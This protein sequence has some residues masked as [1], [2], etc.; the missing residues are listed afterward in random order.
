MKKRNAVALAVFLAFVM[1][2]VALGLLIAFALGQAN[3]NPRMLAGK[4]ILQVDLETAVLEYVPPDPIAQLTMKEAPQMRPLVEALTRAATDDDV[5][6]LIARVGQGGLGIAQ[7]QEIRDAVIAFRAAGKPAYAYAETF[8]EVSSGNASYYL[9]TAFDKIYLQPA[10]D[11]NVT[12][13]MLAS[14]FFRG[15]LDKLGIVPRLGHRYEYKNARNVYTETEM[16]AAHREASESLMR[17]IFEQ[18]TQGMAEGRDL[19]VDE[20][21]QRIAAGPYYGQEAVDAGLVDGLAY[22]DEVYDE[23]EQATDGRAS[24]QNLRPYLQQAG[25]VWGKGTTVALIY[26]VGGITRGES[27][28]S[29]LN[30]SANMGSDTVAT[31]FRAAVEDSKVKAILFRIDCNGG[32]YV[33]SDTVLREV[34]R[35]REAGKPVIVSMGNV[36]ASGGY[37]V[38]AEADKI[39]AQPSTI[40]GSIGV[41][42][43]KLVTAGLWEK[44]GLSWD[45]VETSANASMWSANYDYTDE[46]WARQSDWLDRVYEDFT[47]R[48]AAGRDLPLDKVREIAKGRVWTGVQAKELGLVDALG[49]YTVA[50]DLVREALGLE[51]GA[52]IKL[53]PFPVPKT[54]W[55]GFVDQ[56]PSGSELAIIAAAQVLE[57]VR[58]LV[59][60]AG[61]AGLVET[62]PETLAVPEELIPR[63]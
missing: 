15:T 32:S 60:L 44:I 1:V 16:T 45:A 57:S 4:T 54:F 62:P 43:G 7:L 42:G 36:A 38:A 20:L 25:R 21:K 61:R 40:T 26:G 52:S 18:M 10:G 12:G 24:F 35:A 13:L 47:A 19:S 23:I 28:Y 39:V 59:V 41:V 6:G 11:V 48:V 3:F 58:P 31:A 29:P 2:M 56:V 46:Q 30:G 49:G 63:P 8:G 9:A 50:I 5:V 34:T 27:Q 33:A 37:F 51:P 17:S 14:S 55:Q 53:R 22:R